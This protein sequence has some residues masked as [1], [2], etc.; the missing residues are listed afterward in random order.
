MN[1]LPISKL[2]DELLPATK[3]G[4]L[5]VKHVSREFSPTDEGL[6]PVLNASGR[7]Q[8]SGC[9]SVRVASLFMVSAA[10]KTVINCVPGLS[11]LQTA[12]ARRPRGPA[13]FVE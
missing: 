8:S 4:P 9:S 12:V 11:E 10:S 1:E 2:A 13:T 7:A 5:G 6:D 3:I